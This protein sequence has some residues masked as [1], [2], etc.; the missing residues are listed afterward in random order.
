MVILGMCPTPAQGSSDITS[1]YV[2]RFGIPSVGSRVFVKANL[3]TDGWQ[4]IASLFS[5]VVPASA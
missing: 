5:E 2:A 1:L 4:G 3:V